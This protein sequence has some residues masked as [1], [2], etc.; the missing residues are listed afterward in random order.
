MTSKPTEVRMGKG[1]GAV[2]YWC[3]RVRAG[4]VL[5]EL[6]GISVEFAS[7][8]LHTVSAKLPISTRFISLV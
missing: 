1:K 6:D 2:E 8:I 3:A 7:E 4:R 5:I